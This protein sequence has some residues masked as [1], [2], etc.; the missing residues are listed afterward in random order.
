MSETTDW[1]DAKYTEVFEDEV[2]GLERRRQ[3]DPSFTVHDLEMQLKQ[4][5]IIEGDDWEGR[6]VLGD[7]VLNATIAAWEYYA[8]EWKKEA[9]IKEP[10]L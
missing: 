8:A 5:Y 4:Q 3:H 6:G 1:Q 10:S 2:R 9:D 7:I